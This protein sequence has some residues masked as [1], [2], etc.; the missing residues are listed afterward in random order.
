MTTYLTAIKEK[1]LQRQLYWLIK[2]VKLLTLKTGDI[3]MKKLAMILTTVFFLSGF[4]G[5][6]QMH[7]EQDEQQTS[8][9]QG[10]MQN[11]MDDGMCPMCAQM[12]KQQMPM[13]KYMMM[14]NKLPDMQDQLSLSDE[15]VNQMIDLQAAFKKQQVDYQAT[16]TKKQMQMQKLLKSNAAASDVKKQMKQCA[17]TKVDMKVAAYETAGKMKA[18]LTD[19]QNDKLQNMMMQHSGMMQGQGGMMNQKS[20]EMMQKNNQ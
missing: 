12:M 20:G 14:V 8:Q 13:K 1:I 17:D 2:R 15:Q 16:L 18:L 7:Q 9:Q 11:M 3:T 4:T 6:A 10:M 19:E 5:N